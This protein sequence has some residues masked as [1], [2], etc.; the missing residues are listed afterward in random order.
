MVTSTPVQDSGHPDY[1]TT[2]CCKEKNSEGNA[3]EIIDNQ[4]DQR[5]PRSKADET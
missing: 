5:R 1:P 4:V 3:E 2:G